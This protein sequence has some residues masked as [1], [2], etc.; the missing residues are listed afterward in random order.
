MSVPARRSAIGAVAAVVALA[1]LP[2]T[3][4]GAPPD[5]FDQLYALGQKING[6]M[7]TLTARFTEAT[8][9]TL[10]TKP[11]TARGR[12]WVERPSRVILRYTDPDARVVLID[13]NRM[14]VA[15]PSRN[16]NETLDITTAQSR[17]QKYFVNGSAADLR[18]QFDVDMHSDGEARPNAYYVSMAPKRKQM[19]ETLT[20]LELWVG[21]ASMLLEG[22]KMTFANGDVK[23][24]TFEDVVPNAP[25]DAR[26]FSLT[27]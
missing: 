26:T 16:I 23:T 4:S 15:W 7:R 19:R 18:R 22:M 25:I 2:R 21:R 6:T 27:P 12:L 24:M 3:S 17:V 20:R 10:L 13:G 9:S 11:I 14:I 5:D 1:I 8:A